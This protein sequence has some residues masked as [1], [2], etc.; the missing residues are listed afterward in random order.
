MKNNNK[1]SN[2]NQIKFSRT[3]EEM[4]TILK[5]Y[6]EKHGDGGCIKFGNK[7]YMDGYA[8]AVSDMIFMMS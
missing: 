1:K 6:Q 3:I 2:N 4:Y 8:R 7:D 5:D